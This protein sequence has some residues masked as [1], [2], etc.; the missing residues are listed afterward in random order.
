MI[1]E[2]RLQQNISVR[3]IKTEEELLYFNYFIG[4][5]MSSINHINS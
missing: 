3:N 2:C 1:I 5:D 4:L